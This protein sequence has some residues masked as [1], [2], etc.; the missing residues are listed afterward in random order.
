MDDGYLNEHEYRAYMRTSRACSVIE[1]A[2]SWALYD[3]GTVP[4]PL[5]EQY[6]QLLTAIADARYHVHQALTEHH[7]LARVE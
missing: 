1:E 3:I 4:S 2:L 7:A 5:D 6:A